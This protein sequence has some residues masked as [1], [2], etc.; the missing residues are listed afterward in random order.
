MCNE[1]SGGTIENLFLCTVPMVSEHT[2]E[3][4]RYFIGGTAFITQYRNSL[5]VITANH[6]INNRHSDPDRIRIRTASNGSRLL[7]LKN[8]NRPLTDCTHC[9][10]A[11]MEV[12]ENALDCESIREIHPMR[13]DAFNR[14]NDFNVDHSKFILRGYPDCL[15]NEV[16]YDNCVIKNQGVYLHACYCSS[17]NDKLVHQIQFCDL[18]G[19]DDLRG[20]SGSPVLHISDTIKPG[21]IYYDF[22]GLLIMGTRSSKIGYFIDSLVIYEVLDQCCAKK[23]IDLIVH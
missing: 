18:D 19:V 15:C 8:I 22:A 1:Q 2:D 11:I 16:D 10:I 9:D 6:V 5:F 14:N 23:D 20:F 17:N 3:S 4:Y 12:D 7:P 21:T 13:L